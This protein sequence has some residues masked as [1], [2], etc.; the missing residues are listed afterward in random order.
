[1]IYF[2]GTI[3]NGRSR[4]DLDLYGMIVEKLAKYGEVL[5]PFVA[6]PNEITL[7]GREHEVHAWD[8]LLLARC[9]VV[10]AEVT[11]PS[12]GV[13]Y[14]LGR[15]VELGKR[16][17]CLYRP[18]EGKLLSPMIRGIDNGDSLRTMDYNPEHDL[19][20][21]L[22]QA[23]KLSD[24]NQNK[25]AAEGTPQFECMGTTWARRGWTH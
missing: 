4:Q 24:S 15:A 18:Q 14:E 16:V 23:H 9:D 22:D 10:V 3:T 8:L 6:D 13:G 12:L 21:I 5:T 1:M 7:R 19:D 2:S 17:L 25:T 20:Q 11:L